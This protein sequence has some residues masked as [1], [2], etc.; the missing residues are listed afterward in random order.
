VQARDKLPPGAEGG[1][2][3]SL[4][5]Q[6]L[7]QSVTLKIFKMSA[8]ILPEQGLYAQILHTVQEEDQSSVYSL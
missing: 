5:A 2:T 7:V 6:F 1:S 8:H 3:L 4:L